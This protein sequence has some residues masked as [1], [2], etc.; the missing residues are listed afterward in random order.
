MRVIMPY[1]TLFSMSNNPPNKCFAGAAALHV[2]PSVL[3]CSDSP[4]THREGPELVVAGAPVPL[5]QPRVFDGARSGERED[6]DQARR[7]ED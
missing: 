6:E 7:R 1:A 5:L 4:G 3:L 2:F